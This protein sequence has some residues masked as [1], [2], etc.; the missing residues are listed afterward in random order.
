MAI[1]INRRVDLSILNGILAV[2]AQSQR[3][4]REVVDEK[5]A[6]YVGST[7]MLA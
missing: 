7:E 4:P 1:A 3:L 6:D 2:L 5:M